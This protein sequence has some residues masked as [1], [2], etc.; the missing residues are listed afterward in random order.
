MKTFCLKNSDENVVNAK[1][2][3]T[4]RAIMR[5]TGFI[6]F[7]YNHSPFSNFPPLPYVL[8]FLFPTTKK[9]KP[10]DK[11]ISIITLADI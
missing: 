3:Q 2:E 11:T 1:G 9:E 4:V 5:S 10:F 6:F 7:L 8:P